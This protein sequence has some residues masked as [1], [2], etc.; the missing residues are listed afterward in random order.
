MLETVVSGKFAQFGLK[1]L[2]GTTPT[3]DDFSSAHNCLE[4][5]G[6]QDLASK[7]FSML[8]QGERQQLLIARA[9][10]AAPMLLVLDEACAGMDPGVKEMF[11]AWLDQQLRTPKFP[12]TLLATHHIEEIV[13]GIRQ[14][15][16]LKSGKITCAG[17]KRTVLSPKN[18]ESAYGA[19]L[20]DLREH[21]GRLW[22]IWSSWGENAVSWDVE[23]F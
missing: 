13:P 16:I 1:Y 23:Y 17:D 2:Q 18:I 21:D 6:C 22:P 9:R 10:M 15:L 19:T 5:L 12:T 7:R 4:Q 20:S 3:P 14:A 11:L 8:S